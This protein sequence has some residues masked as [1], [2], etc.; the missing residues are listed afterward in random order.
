MI[1]FITEQFSAFSLCFQ[2]S[3]FSVFRQFSINHEISSCHETT[4]SLQD[5]YLLWPGTGSKT[6][7]EP[8]PA[9]PTVLMETVG[10]ASRRWCTCLKITSLTRETAVYMLHHDHHLTSWSNLADP[11]NM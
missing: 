2:F 7:R 9:I 5:I 11:K 10:C 3:Q 1:A 6:H 8:V 4:V